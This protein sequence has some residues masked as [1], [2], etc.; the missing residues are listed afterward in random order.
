VLGRLFEESETEEEGRKAVS[1]PI[2]PIL[3]FDS[4]PFLTFGHP[5]RRVDRIAS[6][7]ASGSDL[8]IQGLSLPCRAACG[9]W[10]ARGPSL[11]PEIPLRRTLQTIQAHAIEPILCL[12]L[13]RRRRRYETFPRPELVQRTRAQYQR[14]LRG[15][16]QRCLEE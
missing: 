8:S 14:G 13:S 2:L 5:M 4:F 15:S 12:T 10:E 1:S 11:K 6:T 16:K 3:A 7:V 9:R